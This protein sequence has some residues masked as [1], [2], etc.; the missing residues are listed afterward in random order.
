MT[1]NVVYTYQIGSQTVTYPSQGTK[2]AVSSTGPVQIKGSGTVERMAPLTAVKLTSASGTT[3]WA[4]N[5]AYTLA[6]NVA[7]YTY[8]SGKYYPADLSYVSG[9]NYTLT[10]YYDNPMADGGRIRVIIAR[11]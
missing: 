2:F 10:G 5:Q 3:A 4:G 6:D 11:Q 9:G 1:I 8:D 7:V